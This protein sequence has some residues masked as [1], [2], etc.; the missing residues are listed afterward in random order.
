MK[1]N[2][3]LIL[4][5]LIVA[6]IATS[7]VGF[8][9]CDK[10]ED[11]G[12]DYVSQLT[13]DMSSSTL[14]QEATVKNFI[15]GD[16]THF[17]VPSSVSSTGVLKARY[18]AINTPESTGKI[19]DY[20]KKAARFTKEKL[21]SAVSIILESDNSKWNVDSTGG[22]YLV[23]VWYKS[24][25]DTEYRNLNLEILQEGLAVASNTSA[26]RYGETCMAALDQ[27]NRLKR[28]V[29]SGVDDPERYRGEAVEVTLKELRANIESYSGMKVAFEAVVSMED[30]L[31]CYV[32]EYD[33]ETGMYNGIYVYY[34]T[35][36]SGSG[37]AILKPGNRVRIVGLVQYWETGG[38]YQIA[39][40][41]YKPREPEHP[42][43]LKKISEGHSASYSVVDANTFANGKVEIDT[44]EDLVEYDFAMLAMDT[45]ITMNNLYVKRAYTTDEG[46]S[47]GAMT[48]TCDVNGVEIIVRT[49]VLMNNGSL[50]TEDM[51]VG[52]TISVKGVVGYFSGS[53]G[54][55]YQIKVL[56]YT[57]IT[58]NG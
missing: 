44:E 15:D 11:Q 17:H 40:V 50:V 49:D 2:N 13:L 12:I 34:G 45:T 57:D 53:N 14:K 42:D 26:S 33:E 55:Q 19:E 24:S 46:D 5:L 6:V 4:M 43:N 1:F 38:T 21:S 25:T 23:W 37:M 10:E 32:E 48:L 27:A 30:G 52:R 39:D 7:L 41:Q 22:R 3:K 51:L 35:F 31:A 56:K 54:G 36:L 9:A 29:F 47:A 28:N 58:F 8:V 18:L 16:T 20:G